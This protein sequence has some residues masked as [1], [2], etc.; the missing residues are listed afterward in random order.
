MIKEFRE[1]LDDRMRIEAFKSAIDELVTPNSI[2]AEIGTALGTYSF[3]SAKAGAKTVYAIEMAPMIKVAREIAKRNKLDDKITFIHKKSTDVRLPEL[4][5]Y[6]IMEDFSPF[7]L[8]D[9]LSRTLRD[10]R[11]RFLKPGGKFI[12]NTILLKIAV[13]ESPGLH[14]SLNIWKKEN[15]RLYGIDWSDTTRILFNQPRYAERFPIRFLTD[16]SLIRTIDLSKD[17][18]FT[19]DFSIVQS[20]NDSGTIHGLIGWWDCWFTPTQFFSNAPNAPSNTWGQWFFPFQQPIPVAK[21]ESVKINITAIESQKSKQLNFKWSI[22]TGSVRVEQNTFDGSLFNQKNLPRL[23]SP[24]SPILNEEG[25]IT[26][27]ILEKIEGKFSSAEIADQLIQ[28][29]P[30]HF[31]T[32]ENAITELL[33]I[34]RRYVI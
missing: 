8:Y 1:L 32:I 29:F 4:V 34:S 6:I 11:K 23:T 3:F 13:I 19:Y 7:F 31:F 22:E 18:N 5:D 25:K 9:G 2:V 14:N 10:A 26:R 28:R 12:P 15:D 16:E 17:D 20:A 21:G 33:E 27:F 24:L 30:E